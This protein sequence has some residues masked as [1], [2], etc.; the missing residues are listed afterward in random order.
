MSTL[1]HRVQELEQRADALVADA[2]AKALSLRTGAESRLKDE[3]VRLDTGFDA[4]L[5]ALRAEQEAAHA[6]ALQDLAKER[7]DALARVD[8]ISEDR[9]DEMSVFVAQSLASGGIHG[10]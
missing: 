10:H 9:L 2:A 3:L 8:A 6:Q 7:A 4:R 1:I 5:S